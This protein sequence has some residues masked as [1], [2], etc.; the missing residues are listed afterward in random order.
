MTASR[1]ILIVLFIALIVALAK[2]VGALLFRL[3][4]PLSRSAIPWSQRFQIG[5]LVLGPYQGNYKNDIF[6]TKQLQ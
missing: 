3:Y 6:M 5:E 1:W 2:P 4:F